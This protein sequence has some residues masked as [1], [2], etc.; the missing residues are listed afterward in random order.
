MQY[1]DVISLN[2]WSIVISLCN[3]IVI[4]LIL[5]KFLYNPV[6]KAL[7]E[8]KASVDAVY[9]DAR[10]AREEAE[11]AR[12]ELTGRLKGA[13]AEAQSIKAEAEARARAR[14]ER[15]LEA[16]KE[17]AAGIV[18]AAQA[19]AQSEKKRAEQDMRSAVTELSSA[20]AEKLLEREI[21][22]DDRDRMVDEFIDEIGE[23]DGEER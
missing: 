3:L 22:T 20:I 4:Y 12:E 14:E 6:K 18:R 10:S 11:R 5:R 8:R 2:I 9:D 1:S 16:A 7:D 19:E 15:E 23:A 21:N 17:K 13:E